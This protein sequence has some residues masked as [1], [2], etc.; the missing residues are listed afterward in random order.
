MS[1]HVQTTT[2]V[3]SDGYQY[4]VGRDFTSYCNLFSTPHDNITYV[5]IDHKAM[6]YIISPP[7]DQS[8]RSTC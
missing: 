1:Y 2:L 5:N 8:R 6:L 4:K 7:G 3:S